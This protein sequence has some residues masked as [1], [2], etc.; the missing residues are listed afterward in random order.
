[1]KAVMISI[2][3]EWCERIAVGAKTIEVRKTRPRLITPF[4]C[5][6]YCSK[7]KKASDNSSAFC[8]P[9]YSGKI[10]GEFICGRIIQNSGKTIDILSSGMIE[11]TCLTVE[12]IY[13]YANKGSVYFWSISNFI[14]YAT[15]KEIMTWKR[16][17]IS[18][19]PC[20]FCKHAELDPVAEKLNCENRVQRPPQ[21]WCYVE[22]IEHG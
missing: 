4:K 5:Y 10:I 7:P 17:C 2:Q 1:M 21:S 22:E 16:P 9:P 18:D 6:V 8:Q 20:A 14:R 13:R 12:E 11:Q 19:S 15:P 3:P